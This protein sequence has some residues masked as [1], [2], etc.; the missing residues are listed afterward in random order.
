MR[1]HLRSFTRVQNTNEIIKYNFSFLPFSCCFSWNLKLPA[2][3]TPSTK[4]VISTH[5]EQGPCGDIYV[6]LLVYRTRTGLS[7]KPGLIGILGRSLARAMRKV[8]SRRKISW[9]TYRKNE[10][11]KCA[12]L[13]HFKIGI[14]PTLVK[15]RRDFCQHFVGPRTETMRLNARRLTS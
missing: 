5:G 2:S 8:C 3:I 1:R 13:F 7:V 6:V 9:V 10:E 14:D 12:L 4:D 11:E 15:S